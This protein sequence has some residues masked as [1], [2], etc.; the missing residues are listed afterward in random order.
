MRRIITF[1]IAINSFNLLFAQNLVPNGDFEYYSSCPSDQAQLNKAYPWINPST[2]DMEYSGTPDYFNQ[3]STC[4]EED[5]PN[6]YF[7]FQPAHSGVAYSGIFLWSIYFSATLNNVREYIETPLTSTLS[8]NSC[9][10]FKMYVNLGNNCKYT[11]SDIGVYFSDTAVTGITN[12]HPLL[13]IPQINNIAGNTFDTLN[14]TLMSGNYTAIGGEHYIIIGNF[15]N[16]S[17]TTAILVN[18]SAP[19]YTYCFIDD[20]SLT[21]ITGINDFDKNVLKNIYPNPAVNSITIET[22]TIAS[23]STLEILNINGQEIIKKQIK[24]SKT[25]V[26]ISNLTSGMYFV[27]IVSDKNVEVRKIIKE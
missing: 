8:A 27:R 4:S 23:E 20:V 24:D 19:N 7:G 14:W 11:T 2:N 17:N 16:D 26:D 6:N 21:L 10:H 9:Y 15:K 22:A 25:Q 13:F 1:L 12:F 18:N 5:V 3:C